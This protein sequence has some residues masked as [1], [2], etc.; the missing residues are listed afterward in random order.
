VEAQLNRLRFVLNSRGL[1]NSIA[2]ALQVGKRFGI[3]AGRME[4]RLAAYV[5]TV[6]G[7]GSSPSL[8][9][10]AAVLDRNPQVAR[11]LVDKG[12]ELCVHGFVHNDL[13]KLPAAVQR[14]QI[15][16]AIEIFR[17]HR[18]GFTGFRSPYLRYNEATLA[19]VEDA[20]FEYDSNLAFYW[21]PRD[22]FA[23]LHRSE[24]DGLR[25]GLRFYSPASYPADRSLPRFSGRLVEIPV[26]LPDDEIL[27]DRMGW[28]ASR[29]G[30]TWIEMA[31]MA[32]VR[33]ELLTIQLHP[34][35][36]LLLRESL[37]SVLEF[38]RSS[39]A[40]WMANMGEIA[41]WWKHRTGLEAAVRSVGSGR[42]AV[43]APLKAKTNLCL[44]T[45]RQGT[46]HPLEPDSEIAASR[47]PLIGIHPAAAPDLIHR[48]RDMGYLIEKTEDADAY[49]LYFD[50]RS[51]E[52][53]IERAIADVDHP[54]ITDGLWPSPFK[55]ALVVTGDIDCLTLGDFIRRFREG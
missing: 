21:Q 35:R 4:A 10:T 54:L 40:F 42:F 44:A 48:I 19:A 15:E 8:P 34:E 7:Y 30:R 14:V 53:H 41:R 1:R 39:G 45:P 9:I 16:R 49:P 36:I 55:A 2:R 43:S 51:T 11:Q 52:D 50:G 17:R 13:S 5:D 26:S 37:T 46:S 6:A 25:R 29:I 33:G 23:D 20:G 18:I 32:L 38:A 31:R 27:L 22:S 12:V 28:D 3:T 47:K 24:A